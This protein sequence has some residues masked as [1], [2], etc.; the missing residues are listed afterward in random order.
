MLDAYLSQDKPTGSSNSTEL[1]WINRQKHIKITKTL[2]TKQR[3]MNYSL[4]CKINNNTK[5]LR[6]SGKMKIDYPYEIVTNIIIFLK[7][8]MQKKTVHFCVPCGFTCTRSTA[9]NQSKMW[10]REKGIR[11][12]HPLQV[13][14][15]KIF[16]MTIEFMFPSAW[17]I[18]EKWIYWYTGNH[19][20]AFAYSRK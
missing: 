20:N 6:Q 3:T 7:N 4:R 16:N 9:E 2:W 5:W 1:I 18:K 15:S 12:F 17:E 19:Q 10:P 8:G 14:Q 13:N 11:L